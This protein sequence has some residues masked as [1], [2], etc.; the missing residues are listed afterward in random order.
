MW[1]WGERRKRLRAEQED[2]KRRDQLERS[3]FANGRFVMYIIIAPR[4][5]PVCFTPL[6]SEAPVFFRSY[7]VPWMRGD[8]RWFSHS[9]WEGLPGSPVVNRAPFFEVYRGFDVRQVIVMAPTEEYKARLDLVLAD[10]VR[11][12]EAQAE[13]NRLAE[14]STA[15][16]MSV[17]AMRDA[18][19]GMEGD[20]K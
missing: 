17:A 7:V 4:A 6:E 8:L 15:Y 2:R 10:E 1:V 9:S 12:A 13:A 16:T 18:Y 5:A 20:G 3:A 14:R 19:R 11:A